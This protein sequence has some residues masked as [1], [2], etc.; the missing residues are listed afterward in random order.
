MRAAYPGET[1][2]DPLGSRPPVD[3]TTIRLDPPHDT[4]ALFRFL[5]PRA[6]PGVE[7]IAP[8]TYRR[9]WGS[10]PA[11]A[12]TVD[13]TVGRDVAHI[14]LPGVEREARRLLGLDVD[15][16]MVADHLGRDPLLA[17]L[18]AAA[19]GLRVPGAFSP[20]EVGIRTILGQQV[21]VAGATTLAG[22][23][24][25]AAGTA[26]EDGDG[27]TRLFPTPGQLAEADL[28]DVGLTE[29]RRR[30]ILAFSAAVTAGDVVLDGT[31]PSHETQAAMRSIAGIGPW[32]AS[33]VAMRA[34]RDP[35]AFPESDLGIR[36]G[37][38]ALTG[39]DSTAAL[40]SRAERW[41]PYRAY[42]ALYLWR[43]AAA[44]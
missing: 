44:A 3:A 17:P 19:P 4:E 7:L 21:T 20:F 43:A 13:L 22:R 11:T 14:S 26:F 32:T 28:D 39:G 23:V 27:L 29:V 37:F 16:G 15:P 41:R 33:Y 2:R 25:A 12:T 36:K 1:D 38:A 40:R 24:V 9:T 10:D 34:L 18:V 35:D 42:A 8:G 6:I 31:V 30:S 5:I